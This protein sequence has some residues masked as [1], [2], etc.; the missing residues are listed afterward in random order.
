[1]SLSIS[2]QKRARHLETH[3]DSFGL[4]VLESGNLEWTLCKLPVRPVN[5]VLTM[6]APGNAGIDAL[7]AESRSAPRGRG[8]GHGGRRFEHRHDARYDAQPRHR[9]DQAARRH[10]R[11]SCEYLLSTARLESNLDPKASASTSSAKSSSGSSRRE[12]FPKGTPDE[13]AAFISR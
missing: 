4:T 11:T 3:G 1:M 7:G 8:P 6:I 12:S 5:A 9:R 13:L 2:T 10:H